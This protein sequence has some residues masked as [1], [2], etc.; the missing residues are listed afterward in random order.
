MGSVLDEEHQ[1]AGVLAGADG[2]LDAADAQQRQ[3]PELEL[4]DL[5]VRQ[6]HFL[7]RDQVVGAEG[8]HRQAALGIDGERRAGA[9]AQRVLALALGGADAGEPVF[10]GVDL[11]QAFEL[12]GENLAL[13]LALVFEG[14]VAELGPAHGKDAALR[15]AQGIGGGPE[16][17]HAVL[18]GLVDL[19]HVAAP[20]AGLLPR[21][22]QGDADLF[23]G[24]AVADKD[25]PALVAGDAVSAV[26]CSAEAYSQDVLVGAHGV[27]SF[28]LETG[29]NAEMV[30]WP[31]EACSVEPP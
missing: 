13:Q 29:G 6:R 31:G 11:A 7:D 23:P 4:V 28:A 19:D 16:V 17:R 20:E 14:N 27:Q 1:H 10:G 24:N 26:G 3:L 30:L 22:A 21:V 2:N 25:H 5:R 8:A 12:L 15:G 18:G 9:P